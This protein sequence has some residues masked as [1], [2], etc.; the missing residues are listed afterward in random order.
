MEPESQF[1]NTIIAT[2]VFSTLPDIK[3]FTGFLLL[4]ILLIGSALMSG[5][6]VAY[7][8]LG[9]EDMEKLKG[10]NTRKASTALK[11]FSNPEKLLSTILAANTT[12]NI[13]I[14]L[15]AA[16]LSAR[17]YS[18]SDKPVAGFIVNAIIITVILLFFGEIMPKVYAGRA[19]IR[20][21]LLMALP[22]TVIEKIFKP[23]TSLLSFSSYFVK[24]RSG[25]QR[26]SV[27]KGG[28]SD[29]LEMAS[30]DIDEDEK[31]L[32]GIVN[33]GNINVNAIMCPRIDVTALDIK[34]GFDSVVPVIV[35]SGFSR[36]P[37]YSGSFDSVKGILYA[38]DILPYTSSPG[39]FKWQSLLR[40]PYFVPETKKINDLLKEFQTKK[41]HMAIVI[42]EYGGTSG[43]VTLEDILEE[44]VGEITDESDEDEIL[45]RQI[46]ES[47]F[48]FEGKIILHDF[49]KIVDIDE[50]LFESV[51]GDSETLAG[52]I[53]ELT[54]EIPQKGQEVNYHH[55]KFIIESADRRRIKEIRVEIKQDEADAD[56]D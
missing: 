43:I 3:L 53:L 28:L 37:V 6:E 41:I 24:K 7:F 38:K 50:D 8:S 20:I 4:I 26:T 44:I 11:L 22:L 2:G 12:I 16:F 45:Y 55:F 40:P 21:V 35:E 29:A 1:L 14:V 33:F 23:V 30:D 32:K 27:S 42:D 54:G 56:K 18:F 39:T 47:T 46:D 49:C 15:L 36:I 31:L 48:I 19:N 52:L 10:T 5:S 25:A 34:S 51:R 13:A 9:S 17:L